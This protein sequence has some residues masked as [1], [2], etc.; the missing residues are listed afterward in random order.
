LNLP[1]P[2]QGYPVL[3]H[4][5]TSERSRDLEGRTLLVTAGGTQEPIDPV[6]YIGNR[7]S[8]KTGFAI[9]GEAARRAPG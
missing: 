8:G 2:P 3:L 6:R 1:R 4:A 7:S 9:A 5:G